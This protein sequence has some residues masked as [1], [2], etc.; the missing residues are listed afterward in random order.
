MG[1]DWSGR[2]VV[3]AR[4]YMATKLPAPCAECGTTL[5][6]AEPWVIGHRVARSIRPEWT[7]RVD[8]WQ[9]ECK[10]CSN[11][12][13]QS[14][15][16]AKAKAD[17]LREYGIFPV[18]NHVGTSP[19]LPFSPSATTTRPYEAREELLWTTETLERHEWLKGFLPI[20]EDASPPLFMSPPHAD[21]VGSY[22]AQA[23]EWIETT[24]KITLRW[25]QRLAITRQLEHREDGTLCHRTVLESAP[26]RAGKSVRIR[27]MALWRMAH[28][29]LIGEV[30]T[31][32]HC[33]NDLPICREIQR[34]AWRWAEEQDW[35]VT[36]ANGKEA[37]EAHDG[38][39]WLVRSQS[40]VYGWDAGLAVVDEAWDVKPDTVSEGLEPAMLERLWAQLHITST[41]H[42]RATSLMRGKLS[43]ALTADD[44]ETLL[45][46][47]GARPEDDPADPA[48]WRAASPHWSEDRRRMI[49]AKYTAALAGETDAEADDP[50]PL[51][52][53][54]SQYLNVWRLSAKAQRGN[55]VIDAER[56]DAL[57]SAVPSRKPD[58]AAI[59]SWFSEGLSAAF[60]WRLPGNGVVVRVLGFADMAGA[61]EAIRATA[62]AGQVIVGASLMDAPELA[63]MRRTSG[64]GRSQ[65]TVQELG[66]LLSERG[67]VHDGSEHLRGQVLDLRT[68]PGIDGPRLTSKGRADA[69]KAALWAVNS[70]RSK[71]SKN[72]KVRI[73]L[74][75]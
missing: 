40:G 64:Q 21:A 18:E 59:E 11:A 49:A 27:G 19:P 8:N 53:W 3:A 71:Y 31:V 22:G 50:D 48:T 9:H 29:G 23:I 63:R 57:R 75:T 58:A 65:W 45:M 5:T 16:I 12:S 38:S 10:K 54:A 24:Q 56:W 61:V 69:I 72:S 25:W 66:R 52:G 62:F 47:W 37:I 73:L 74:P 70:V 13:A 68:V 30:Q 20:P 14:V 6:G 15:V 55:A 36:K 39:R 67:F 4:A 44:G 7:W 34:G 51:L 17:A 32:V 33:G 46:L 26:R 42:R 2:R 60:A 35:T 1:D 28:P 43:A 41:A